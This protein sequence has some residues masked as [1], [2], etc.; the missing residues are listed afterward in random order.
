MEWNGWLLT[1]MIVELNIYQFAHHCLFKE[2][3]VVANC[4]YL[5]LNRLKGVID[6]LGNIQQV[7][8]DWKLTESSLM[9]RNF[10]DHIV[11]AD[12]HNRKFT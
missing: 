9:R 4:L 8:T 12:V 2:F 10:K 11:K 3:K 7:N 1:H 5:H 6:V